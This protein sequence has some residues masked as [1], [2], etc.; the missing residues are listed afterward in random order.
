MINEL[1]GLSHVAPKGKYADAEHSATVRREAQTA[2]SFL[3]TQF[4][5]RNRRL[6]ALTQSGTE[7]QTISYRSEETS[8]IVSYSDC[9]A[10]RVFSVWL[11]RE[12][13]NAG[14]VVMTE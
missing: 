10:N 2:V 9:P 12:E 8:S 4:D 6:K 5:S 1:D 11:T 13:S 3:E 7:L 14:E